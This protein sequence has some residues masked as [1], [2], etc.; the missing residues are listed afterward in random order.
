M[1]APMDD[2][3][4]KTIKGLE[5]NGLEAHFV[6][7]AQKVPALLQTLIKAGARVAVGGSMTLFQCGVIEHLRS[8]R[9]EFLD[10]YAPGL[11]E[12]QIHAVHHSAFL[13]DAYL[14]S[15]NAITQKG[16]LYNVDGN[17]NRIAAM[18][19]GPQSVIVVAGVNKLVPTL[20]DAVA[21]V[22]TVSAP[23][24]CKRR[25]LDTP[26]A[27]SGACIKLPGTV[28]DFADGCRSPQK[29]CCNQLISGRQRV[30]G[31]IKVI[32]VN[33]ELGC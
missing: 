26:C 12:E 23:A 17:S 11:S 1:K 22:K 24:I 8:G 31:R 28:E 21:R 18:A 7:A 14:C 19:Y 13:A 6:Q 32:L 15:S 5:H 29:V 4:E 27:Q 10:R 3:V 25:G 20:K 16:E 9:Y 2:R 30:P 33:E